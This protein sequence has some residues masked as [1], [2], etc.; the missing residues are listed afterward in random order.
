MI[1]RMEWVDG[2]LTNQ[3]PAQ[4]MT[5]EMVQEEGAWE[6][7]LESGLGNDAVLSLNT[8]TIYHLQTIHEPACVILT[9]LD[10]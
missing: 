1:S 2:D 10:K 3:H 6:G 9:Q 7:A 4:E 5:W 8:R